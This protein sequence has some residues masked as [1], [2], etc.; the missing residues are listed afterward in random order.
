MSAVV[1]MTPEPRRRPRA[2]APAAPTPLEIANAA[3]ATGNVEMF[4]EAVALVKE[5]EIF[6]GRKA[7]NNA[8]ADARAK[9]PII[10]KNVHVTSDAA[11][12]QTD[13]WH[14]DL[15]EIVETVTPILSE[16]G[17]SH[18]WRPS[19]KPGES[20]EVTCIISHRDGHIEESTVAAGADMTGGKNEIQAVK[21]TI[22]YLE[23]ITLMAALGLAS[24]RDDDDGRAAGMPPGIP[25]TP[26]AGSISQAQA[27]ELRNSLKTKGINAK[28]FLQWTGQL[29]GKTVDRIEDIPET[30]YLACKAGIMKHQGGQK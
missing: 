9:L 20:I 22:K 23:R 30:Q 8:L 14:E 4:R 17:L 18:R 24:R 5:L 21:S 25:Y 27:D 12:A 28:A 19:A 6:A 3:L 7:F 16:C 26:P 13:Y 1:E 2:V 11:G 15:A 29:C 10:R